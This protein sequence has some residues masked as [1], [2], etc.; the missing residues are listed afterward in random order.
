[1]GGAAGG[2]IDQD[3]VSLLSQR[4]S[5]CRAFV[6]RGVSG[7]G[8]TFLNM[9]YIFT[10]RFQANKILNHDTILNLKSHVRCL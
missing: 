2:K 3:G 10:F 9:F 4:E 8:V 1:M 7:S 6:R 5:G